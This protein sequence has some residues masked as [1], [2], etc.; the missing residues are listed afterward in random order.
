MVNYANACVYKICCNDINIKDCYV[1][2]TCNFTRRKF[3][4]KSDCDNVNTKNY[5]FNVYQFI[6]ANGGWYNW[7]MVQIEAYEAKDKRDLHTRE[8]FYFEQLGATLNKCVP[9][10]TKKEY[11]EGNK[12]KIKV[13]NKA[14]REANKDKIKEYDKLYRKSN[15]DKIKAYR[16]ANKD[17][18]KEYKEANKDKIKVFNKAYREA[19]KD[20]ISITNKAYY[21]ANK[22][23]L[24]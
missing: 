1:G 24:I 10:Q 4:H 14:Y 2:S 21:Q 19:N 7:D 6:R 12:D 13:F 18:M 9:N 17:K 8:R 5:N 11:R 23:K 3:A 22:L 20:K 15:K 16:E